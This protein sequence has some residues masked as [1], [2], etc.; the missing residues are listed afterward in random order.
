MILN[1]ENVARAIFSPK[2]VYRNMILPAA[3]ELR[4]Q[5]GEEYVSVMHMI[6]ESWK[7]DIMNFPQRKNR[8]LYGYMQK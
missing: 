3:F 8:T 6:F 5:I 7:K 1:Q 4:P 2:M